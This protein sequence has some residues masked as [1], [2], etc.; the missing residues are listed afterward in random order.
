MT[1]QKKFE[2]IKKLCDSEMLDDESGA[3]FLLDDI[4]FLVPLV[5]KLQDENKDLTGQRDYFRR[6][7]KD[8]ASQLKALGDK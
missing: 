3:K 6:G 8:L 2:E 4:K 1:D 7:V 5:E